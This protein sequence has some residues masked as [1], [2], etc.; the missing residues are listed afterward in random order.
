MEEAQSFNLQH[1]RKISWFDS[2]RMFLDQ[3]HP[4]Q[5]NRKNFLKSKTVK[6][7]RPPYKTGEEILNQICH[8]GIRKVTE[9]DAEEVNRRIC[10]SCGWKNKVYFGICHIRALT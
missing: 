9:L 10:N 5:R 6:R 1:G 7:L 3:H 4:F 2:H 8:L